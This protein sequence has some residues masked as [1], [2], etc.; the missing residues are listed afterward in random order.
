MKPPLPASLLRQ[1]RDLLAQP[2]SAAPGLWERAAVLLARQ[3]L[4]VALTTYWR[5]REPNVQ[6]VSMRAQLLCLGV[7]MNDESAAGDVDQL[8]SDLSHACH[9]DAVQP[10]PSAED[11]RFWLDETEE[12]CTLL[13]RRAGHPTT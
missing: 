2:P 1:A 3:A 13:A 6:G 10:A 11:A 5:A 7:S 12:L 9:V 4:E 8:W